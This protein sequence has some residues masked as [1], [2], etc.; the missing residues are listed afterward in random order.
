MANVCSFNAS[1]SADS[2]GT[3]ASYAWNFGDGT[4]GTGVNPSHAYAAAGGYTATLTVTDNRGGTAGTSVSVTAAAPPNV[5]PVASYAT[6]CTFL[7]CSFDGS[8]SS[9][10]DGTITSY[11]WDFGDGGTATGSTATH[12]FGAGG[13]YTVALTVTDNSG[14][15]TTLTK[16][17][18]VIPA[19]T[20]NIAYRASATASV[21]A[22]LAK[23][24]VPAS[25]QAGDGLVLFA[26][27]NT[28]TNVTTGPAGWTFLGE[29]ISGTDTRTRLYSKVAGACD[30]GRQVSLTYAAA[31]K[32]DLSLSAYS[33]TDTT[34]P[35]AAFASAAETVSRT[36]HTT[37]SVNV[38]AAGSW[39]VSFWAD[40][41]SATT[42][43]TAPAGQVQR[44]QS[45]GTSTGRITSLEADSGAPVVAGA[46][47][48]QTATASSASAKATMWSVVLNPDTPNVLPTASATGSCV[49]NVCTFDAS[50]SV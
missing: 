10:S 11:A 27:S 44:A 32:V 14:A 30:A 8:G 33:G 38:P 1:A 43:W 12:T 40:K 31:T 15:P 36:T 7:A 2:D 50:A 9:D 13:T 42:A 25:V 22:A 45:I 39:V 46:W 23:V 47:T 26:T 3:I 37:P 48:G 41:S 6:A 17:V 28:N 18:M 49:V 19:P 34:T 21:N 20:S 24:T 35:V 29:Q 5:P 4:T 16:Q